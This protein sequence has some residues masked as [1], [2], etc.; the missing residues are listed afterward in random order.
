MDVSLKEALGSYRELIGNYSVFGL[1]TIAIILFTFL[2]WMNRHTKISRYL[3]LMAVLGVCLSLGI[4]H[5]QELWSHFDTFLHLNFYQNPYVYY[6]NML[7]V[8]SVLFLFLSSKNTKEKQKK[9][10][11]VLFS[12]LLINAIFQLYITGVVQNHSLLVL[13]NT[14]PMIFVGNLLAFFSYLLLIFWM[15]ES[16][17]RKTR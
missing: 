10:V 4:L 8:F 17:L 6:W 11:L 7:L 9:W 5:F 14:Y 16:R 3:L 12:I 15:V 13:G 1:I 2:I